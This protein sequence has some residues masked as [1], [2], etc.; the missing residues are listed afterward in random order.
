MTT[1]ACIAILIAGPL[2]GI[3]EAAGGSLADVIEKAASPVE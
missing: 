3:I 2:A 1:M